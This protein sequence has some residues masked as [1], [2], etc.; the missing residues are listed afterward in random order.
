[1]LTGKHRIPTKYDSIRPDAF[2]LSKQIVTSERE[3][4]FLNIN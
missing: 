2:L 4:N 1:M 3:I